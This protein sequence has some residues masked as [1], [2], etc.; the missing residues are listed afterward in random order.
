VRV[1]CNTSLESSQQEL[2][3]CFRPHPNPRSGHEVITPR[4]CE[5]SNFGSFG[6]TPKGESQNKK[7]FG[8]G[9]CREMKSI[10]YGGRWWLPPSLGCGE[11]CE[12]EVAR[13]LS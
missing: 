8:C 11:S 13:G 2:Q 6:G 12:S 4:S 7:P 1:I 5:S 9:P 3:L 10:L